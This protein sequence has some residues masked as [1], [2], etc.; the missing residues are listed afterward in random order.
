V[1]PEVEL[2][3]KVQFERWLL[4][5]LAQDKQQNWT[6]MIQL[7]WYPSKVYRRGSKQ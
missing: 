3:S 5:I 7:T 1:K 2:Q 4:P 6:G